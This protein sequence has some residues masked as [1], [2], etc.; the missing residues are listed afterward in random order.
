MARKKLSNSER[1]RRYMNANPHALPREIA[2]MLKVNA[3]LV[4]AVK[5]AKKA[6]AL[7]PN[8]TVKANVVK[9]TPLTPAV[10]MVNQPPHYTAG[11]VETIDYIAA[12]LSRDEFIGY[13]KGSILKY[14]SR[15][16]K[17]DDPLTDA[18]KL[19]WYSIKLRDLLRANT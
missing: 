16:G 19:T 13:L 2:K 18:G 15:I 6:D 3:N 1:I 9:T 17:K 8:V 14:G 12:K 5:Y 7:P 11:G 10:D 4:Y